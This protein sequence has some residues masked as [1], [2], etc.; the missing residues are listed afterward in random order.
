MDESGHNYKGTRDDKFKL[1]SSPRRKRNLLTGLGPP[2]PEPKKSNIWSGEGISR[3][4]AFRSQ[5]PPIGT[6]WLGQ[7]ET[8]AHL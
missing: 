2:I 4:T 5:V 6:N 8:A 7:V 3:G 1:A